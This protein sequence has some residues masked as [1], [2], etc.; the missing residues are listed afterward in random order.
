MTLVPTTNHGDFQSIK[1]NI[2]LLSSKTSILDTFNLTASRLVST[3]AQKQL[4]SVSDLTNWVAGTA[5]QITV[6][7][8]TDGT[9]T[10]STPQDIHTGASPEFAQL[11]I[12]GATTYIDRDV[13]NNLTFTDAVTGTKTLAE[14]AGGGMTYKSI[15]ALAQSEGDLHLS[16][17]ATWA[18]SKALIKYIRI[19]TSSTN[20]DL[21]IL[22][23]DNS[24]ATNDA[25]IPAM[26][27]GDNVVGNATLWL[28]LPYEDEDASGEVHLYWL[29]NSGS[30]T[31]D[32]Y[33]QA[34]E[35]S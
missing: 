21:Y 15:T 12:D 29:D 30:N 33:I 13:S 7:D 10:L 35:L 24:Y 31:A 26:K 34:I 17:G 20:W 8:D 25:T 11:R 6:T 19:V 22:Q 4:T 27:I 3:G 16:D 5:N 9:I 23:N 1:R 32:I 2:E 14:L 18:V 28:D